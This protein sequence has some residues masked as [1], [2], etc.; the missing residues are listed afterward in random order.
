MSRLIYLTAFVFWCSGVVVDTHADNAR[1]SLLSNSPFVPYA[2]PKPEAPPT[3]PPPP[4][5]GT[6]ARELVF[7]GVLDIGGTEYYSI[8]DKSL[9]KSLLLQSG[10]EGARFSIVRFHADGDRSIEVTAGGRTERIP[11]A[12]SD[13]S[14]IP[15]T[16]PTKANAAA[17]NAE[18][19]LRQAAGS[20]RPANNTNNVNRSGNQVPRR[21]IIP[22]RQAD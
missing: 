8:F 9:N 18:A 11:L 3:P 17:Q 4:V 5:T 10:Q 22:R 14:P 19:R 7:N 2:E 12:I 1:E 16:L 15:T 20:A 13:G 6:L 21:R